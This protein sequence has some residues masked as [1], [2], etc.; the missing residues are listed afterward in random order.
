MGL[1]RL[2]VIFLLSSG[3]FAQNALP[4]SFEVAAVRPAKPEQSILDFRVFP[5]GRLSVTNLTLASIIRQAYGLKFNQLA[6]GPAWLDTDRFNIEAKAPTDAKRPEMMLMLQRLLEDRFQLKVQR[7]T[8]EGNVYELVVASRGPKLKESTADQSYLRLIRHTPPELPGVLYSIEGQKVSMARF[9][10]DLVGQVQRPVLDR[11]G[12]VGEFDFKVN[13]AVDGH[14]EEGPSIFT[15]LQDQLGL[16]LRATKGPVEMLV[17][18]NAERP[19]GD[20]N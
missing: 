3:L 19:R 7:E 12:L 8:R 11:T 1:R 6:G 20:A 14:S 17:V 4:P 9:A 13:Y 16:K 10:D 18:Q 15:A 5:G 2:S